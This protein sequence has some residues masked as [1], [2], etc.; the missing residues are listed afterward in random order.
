MKLDDPLE[1]VIDGLLTKYGEASERQAAL[2]GTIRD[3]LRQG[4]LPDIEA[5]YQLLAF[6]NDAGRFLVDTARDLMKP[7]PSIFVTDSWFLNDLLN[8]LTPGPHEEITYVSGNKVGR[9]RLLNRICPVE[10]QTHSPIHARATAKSCA[11]ALI[12]MQ[13]WGCP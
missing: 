4:R 12:E 5:A 6:W 2:T 7:K 10:I 11:D 13:E 1:E 9:L 3:Q 8:H